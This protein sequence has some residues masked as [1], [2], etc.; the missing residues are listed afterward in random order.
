MLERRTLPNGVAFLFSARLESDGFSV[1]FT[2]RTGG[3]SDGSFASL[4]LGFGSGDRADRVVENRRVAASALGLDVFA[5][6]RQVHGARQLRVGSKGAGAGFLDRFD[7]AGEADSLVTTSKRVGLAVLAADCVPVALTDARAGRMAVVHAGWRGIAA[8]VVPAA[9]KPFSDR[10]AVRAVIGPCVGPDHYEVDQEVAF[11]V[12]AAAEGGAVLRRAVGSKFLLDLSGTVAR[13]LKEHGVRHVER[14]EACTACEP[15]R[16]FSH[17]RDG[18]T[19]R[20]ALIAV[21]LD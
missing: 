11:S 15:E 8:G 9:L 17:R 1:A 7:A 21:R 16:F 6:G 3:K 13:I 19:G 14:A 20:Q 4:N 5:V 12:S 10:G 18:R 2:E